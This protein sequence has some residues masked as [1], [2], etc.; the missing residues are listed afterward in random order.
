[1]AIKTV[2]QC[3]NL[4]TQL[5]R[6]RA[7]NAAFQGFAKTGSINSGTGMAGK[8]SPKNVSKKYA[9]GR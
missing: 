9:P 7:Q 3:P 8:V 5:S 2:H 6:K 4:Q 1:M